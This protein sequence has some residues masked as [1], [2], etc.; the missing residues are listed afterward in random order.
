MHGY[1]SG[2]FK[3]Q[4]KIPTL[5]PYCYWYDVTVDNMDMSA[6]NQPIDNM[7]ESWPIG[8]GDRLDNKLSIR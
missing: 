1:L 6:S 8:L 4:D 2:G 5:N 3:I 7:W